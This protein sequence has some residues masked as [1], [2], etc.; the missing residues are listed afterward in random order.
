MAV[1]KREEIKGVY[2]DQALHCLGCF[3]GR[4]EDLELDDLLTAEEVE[5]DDSLY[6]CDECK[7]QI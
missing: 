3:E 7:K 1:I 5:N 6:F 2:V 4:L